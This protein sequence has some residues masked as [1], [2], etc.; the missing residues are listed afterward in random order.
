MLTRFSGQIPRALR[1][2]N[3][4]D[5]LFAGF[6]ARMA[7]EHLPRRV[8]FWEMFGGKGY[9]GVQGWDWMKDLEVDINAFGFKFEGWHEAA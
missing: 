9:S 6:V 1:R 2:R 4:D 8:M 7:E 3:A 5:I